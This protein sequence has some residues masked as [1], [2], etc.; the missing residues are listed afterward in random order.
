MFSFSIDKM[1]SKILKQNKHETRKTQKSVNN[2]RS[3]SATEWANVCIQLLS[4]KDSTLETELWFY[5]ITLA[6]LFL[7][8]PYCYPMLSY[9]LYT[10]ILHVIN[11][12]IWLDIFIE[13]FP[14]MSRVSAGVREREVIGAEIRRMLPVLLPPLVVSKQLT[15]QHFGR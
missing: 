8:A 6:I 5:I 15:L 1:L 4:H 3:C 9:R 2:H 7:S 11:R 12:P 14:W 10:A 13:T